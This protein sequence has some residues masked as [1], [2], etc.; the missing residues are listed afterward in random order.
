M[1]VKSEYPLIRLHKSQYE[2]L[3]LF[4]PGKD[5]RSAGVIYLSSINFF[6]FLFRPGDF[7][8]VVGL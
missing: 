7:K 2:V 8:I 6:E 1:Q 3:T 4:L 5:V